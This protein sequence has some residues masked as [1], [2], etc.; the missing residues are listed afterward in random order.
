MVKLS[1][2]QEVVRDDLEQFESFFKQQLQSPVPLLN[3]ITNHIY[4]SKGKQLR[5]LLVF[6]SAK[7]NGEVGNKTHVGAALMELLHTATLIH[8]DVVD[9]ANERR[10]L[11]SI[12]ALWDSKSAVLAGDF[13]FSRGMLV[14]LEY[15]AFDFLRITAR[16]TK[17]I[18]EGEL[19]QMDRARKLETSEEQYFEIIRQKTASLIECCTHIGATSV[20]ASEERVKAMRSYG[21]LL[22][23]AFQVRDDVLDYLSGTGKAA[24]NDIRE[25][26]ITLPLIYALSKVGKSEQGKIIELVACAQNNSRNVKQVVDFVTAN[27]GTEYA[28]EVTH[29]YCDRAKK[30]L[31]IF[32]E[33]DAKT[34][35]CQLADY[36]LEREK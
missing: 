30:S 22:G 8:D 4:R 31:D 11:L 23:T 10:N 18:S 21:D 27:G 12:K 28:N 35:L 3:A 14:A 1:N 34:A 13:L 9:D 19:Q 29:N 2:I 33:S 26:K 5:P 36:V 25:K 20:D 6:L 32:P 15:D 17:S 16:V 7:L 24:G